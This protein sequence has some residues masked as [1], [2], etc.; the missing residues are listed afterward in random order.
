MGKGQAAEKIRLILNR[1]LQYTVAHFTYGER[2]MQLHHYPG[3]VAHKAL[4]DDLTRQVTKFYD[5][6]HSGRIGIGIPL[7]KFIEDLLKQ[8][9]GKSDMSYAPFLTA[10]AVA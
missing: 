3:F 5:E 8:H 10:K 2:L 6:V 4:H 9:I 7:L 1:L